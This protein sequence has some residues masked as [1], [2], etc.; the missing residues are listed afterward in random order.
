METLP[1]QFRADDIQV[2]HGLKMKSPAV[3]AELFI[4]INQLINQNSLKRSAF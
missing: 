3:A 4:F 2:L 1:E